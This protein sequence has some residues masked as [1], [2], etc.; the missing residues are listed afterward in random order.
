M[1]YGEYYL[2]LPNTWA[3]GNEPVLK[4]IGADTAWQS[5]PE[6]Y[7]GSYEES[8]GEGASEE[9]IWLSRRID[10]L[11]VIAY[12]EPSINDVVRYNGSSGLLGFDG[13]GPFVDWGW[14]IETGYFKRAWSTRCNDAPLYSSTDRPVSS[15][16]DNIRECRKLLGIESAHGVFKFPWWQREGLGRFETA[17]PCSALSLLALMQ[18]CGRLVG[19]KSGIGYFSDQGGFSGNQLSPSEVYVRIDAYCPFEE[20]H[21]GDWDLLDVTATTPRSPADPD[22]WNKMFLLYWKRFVIPPREQWPEGFIKFNHEPEEVTL[23]P[24][25]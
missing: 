10:Q 21:S 15:A 17:D 13:G 5:L 4:R 16:S 14:N 9:R 12:G 20:Q 11:N 6:L 1:K 2:I 24:S 22:H 8:I 18:A 25:A 7:P 23:W 19:W 3:S